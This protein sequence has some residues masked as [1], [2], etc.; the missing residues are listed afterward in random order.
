MRAPRH[1]GILAASLLAILLGTGMS[2]CNS[3]R[4]YDIHVTFDSTAFTRADAFSVH[5]CKVVV[6]G[7]DS[8]EFLLP[9]GQCP[10]MIVGN[11]PLDAGM[12]EFST[13]ASSG[14][15][16]FTLEAFQGLGEL[17]ACMS[18]KGMT[19]L[20]VGSLVTT[21]GDLK[22]MKTGMTCVGAGGTQ[23]DGG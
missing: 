8:S 14:S 19:T 18:G 17:P 20:P 23:V 3:Y 16:T 10:N 12:F 7:A 4:Y 13:F 1:A 6:S 9:M 22:I 5:E 2:G 21:P 11:D 15:L